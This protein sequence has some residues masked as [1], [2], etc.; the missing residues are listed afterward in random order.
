M[1]FAYYDPATIQLG[2]CRGELHSGESI[3]IS[4]DESVQNHLQQ[5]VLTTRS[6]MGLDSPN[7][8]LP[9]YEPSQDYGA[10]SPVALP[11]TNPLA[12]HLR[13]FYEQENRPI[14]GHALAAP[15]EITSYFCI[16][17]DHDGNKLVAV[18]RASQ[19]KAVL[20]SH[21]IRLVDDSLQAVTDRVFKLDSDF[22]LLIVDETVQVLRLPAFEHLAAI[23][24][25]I[26]AA[27]IDNTLEL[28]R[29]L[30]AFDFGS[31]MPFVQSHKKAARLVAALK[32]RGDLGS[33]SVTNFRRECRRSGISVTTLDGKVSPEEGHELAFL[34][35]L[36]RRR[37]VVSLVAGRW[38]RYEAGSRKSLG[39]AERQQIR[40]ERVAR[41]RR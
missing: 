19:F 31:L 17:H 24:E 9:R 5:M 11:L 29:T 16:I 37:Y 27:A 8:R 30:P 18:K 7:A 23:E 2:V 40:P 21:L 39:T 15:E 14:G 36:D 12:A 20:K 28:S 33:T 1:P 35:M 13:N 34:Q 6:K 32:G 26:R 38:E 4:V 3:I 10:D 22:D 41:A 25:Q